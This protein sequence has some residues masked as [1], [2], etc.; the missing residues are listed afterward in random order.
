[1]KRLFLFLVVLVSLVGLSA[2]PVYSYDAAVTA[3]AEFLPYN[4]KVPNSRVPLLVLVEGEDSDAFRKMLGDDIRTQYTKRRGKTCYETTPEVV[5]S[6]CA[7]LSYGVSEDEILESFHSHGYEDGCFISVRYIGDECVLDLSF[8][9]DGFY[10][11][12]RTAMFHYP[13]SQLEEP[14]TLSKPETPDLSNETPEKGIVNGYGFRLG[15]IYRLSQFSK[16]V[17]EY[18]WKSTPVENGFWGEMCIGGYGN[19]GLTKDLS[20]QFELIYFNTH[21]D[22]FRCGSY[23]F[24]VLLRLQILK[25]FPRMGVYGGFYP[26]LIASQMYLFSPIFEYSEVGYAEIEQEMIFGFTVGADFEYPIGPFHLVLDGRY[27]Q[28]FE[29]THVMADLD[30]GTNEMDVFQRKGIAIS[31][32]FRVWGN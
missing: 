31:L 11:P 26:S 3:I 29:A 19:V 24:P 14:K 25:D 32:G 8:V 12:K 27:Y 9:G 20:L 13:V 23:D 7:S 6:L 22:S 18:G 28:D 21:Y 10:V 17:Y 30:G 15:Y 16:D 4:R 2:T 1:M 5:Q